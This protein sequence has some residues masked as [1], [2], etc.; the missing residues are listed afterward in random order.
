M[1]I[2]TGFGLTNNPHKIANKLRQKYKYSS[3]PFAKLKYLANDINN[4]ALD[5]NADFKPELYGRT[6]EDLTDMRTILIGHM[7]DIKGIKKYCEEHKIPLIIL[8]LADEEPNDELASFF[9]QINSSIYFKPYKN[10]M[11]Y[12]QEYCDIIFDYMHS[13]EDEIA[14]SIN[15]YLIKR[16]TA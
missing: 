6:D 5:E 2:L 11:Q 1:I 16:L 10:K 15:K 12:M 13:T 9:S 4:V 7:Y 3:R 8:G 14:D